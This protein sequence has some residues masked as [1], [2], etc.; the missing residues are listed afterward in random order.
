[1]DN[2]RIRIAIIGGGLAGATAA[3]AL[4]RIP[5]IDVHVFESAPQFSERGAAVGL[6]VNAQRA[7]EQ[8]LPSYKN[9]L[10][11]AGAVLMGSSRIILVSWTM[12]TQWRI[13][14]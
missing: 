8:I 14:R 6:S 5:R 2:E 11:K 10:E 4:L 13:A 3:N 7:L 9:M 12:Y 1:M